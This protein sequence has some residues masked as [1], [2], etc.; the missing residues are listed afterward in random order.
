M[1][2]TDNQLFQLLTA[3]NQCQSI[4]GQNIIKGRE[5]KWSWGVGSQGQSRYDLQCIMV[6]SCLR[7]A[8]EE[9][10]GEYLR[11]F[12]IALKWI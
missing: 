11:N 8:S 10:G 1:Q 9:G 4:A 5:K 12:Y 2:V 3:L 6:R 7:T